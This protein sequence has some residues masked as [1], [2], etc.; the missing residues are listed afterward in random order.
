[1]GGVSVCACADG[2]PERVA[3]DEGGLVGLGR[4]RLA[5]R[6][7]VGGPAIVPVQYPPPLTLQNRMGLAHSLPRAHHCHFRTIRCFLQT[8]TTPLLTH[9]ASTAHTT[10][11]RNGAR[12]GGPRTGGTGG[13]AEEGS[14]TGTGRPRGQ[15]GPRRA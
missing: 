13:Q 15:A 6:V 4:R 7:E 10:H 12:T 3:L 5:E 9:T 8:Q 14:G 11:G 2:A 1:M